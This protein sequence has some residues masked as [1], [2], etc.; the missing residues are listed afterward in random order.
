[1]TLFL[2]RHA[3]A[4]SRATWSGDDR[5]RPLDDEG[6]LTAIDL[7]VSLGDRGVERLLSS[8]YLRCRQTLEPLGARLR[9]PVVDE[10]TLAEGSGAAQAV[11]LLHDLARAGTT[12]ALCTHGDLIPTVIRQ[13]L[14]DGISIVGERGS[15]KGSTWVLD[16]RGSDLVRASY[17]R[18]PLDLE[19]VAAEIS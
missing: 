4:G 9:L 11:D 14:R 3:S 13:L 5:V 8:P 7:A 18:R 15:D 2:V 12:A 6:R 10:P 16:T 19:G 1:M 17:F